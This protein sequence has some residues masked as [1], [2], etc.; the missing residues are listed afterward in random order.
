MRIVR[1]L[2]ILVASVTV[3]SGCQNLPSTEP[4]SEPSFTEQPT[5]AATQ[6][7]E[8]GLVAPAQVF[9]GDCDTLFTAEELSE[10]LGM[11]ISGGN[12]EYISRGGYT[13]VEQHGGLR[14]GWGHPDYEGTVLLLV[15][16]ED[17]VDYSPLTDCGIGIE[18]S[19]GC[20][21]EAVRNGIRLS[22]GVFRAD[23]DQ[24]A[25]ASAQAALL[26]LFEQRADAAAAVPLPLQPV[27]AW[28]WP[29]DCASVIG[30]GD[31]SAV[32]GLGAT[33]E[34]GAGG[35]S[36]GA[37]FTPAEIELAGNFPIPYCDVRN[38][39]VFVYFIALGGSRW[40]ESAVAALPGAT[41]IA[42]EGIDSVV[43]SPYYDDMTRVDA[44]DGPNWVSF[45]V[46][47]SSNAGAL[48]QALVAAL[49]TTAIE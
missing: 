27:G 41:T 35:G 45:S 37:Y 36:T 39:D 43:L 25:L 12:G 16:P 28:A 1:G 20:A 34:V 31:F 3:L 7:R 8:T 32:P 29:V 24:T 10:I 46:R 22:G 30:A 4:E 44:F 17:A 38:G 48:A 11:P 9:G 14:C 33:V 5:P 23:N 42:V 18:G 26:D 21:L 40:A 15:I 13:Y 19:T 49:D 2:V 6:A 47:H